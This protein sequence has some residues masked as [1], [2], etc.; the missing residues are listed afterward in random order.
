ML[1]LRHDIIDSSKHPTKW[2]ETVGCRMVQ[3]IKLNLVPR[4]MR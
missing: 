1:W 3:K 4:F 2:I